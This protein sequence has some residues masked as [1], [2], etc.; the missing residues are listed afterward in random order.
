MLALLI[1]GTLAVL[2]VAMV[3]WKIWRRL[4]QTQGEF[5]TLQPNQFMAA[6][7]A[8]RTI[9]QMNAALLRFQLS[10]DPVERQN[11]AGFVRELKPLI[12]QGDV[13]VRDSFAQYLR[14]TAGLLEHPLGAVRKDSADRVQEQIDSASM[15]LRHACT[16]WARQQQT[17]FDQLIAAGAHSAASGRRLIEI[18]AILLVALLAG[19]VFVSY[20][21]L[22]SRLRESEVMLERQE[23]LA[24][25]GTLATGIAHEIRNPLA[26]IK[27]R[28]FSLK[29]TLPASLG[30][31]EDLVV[32]KTQIDRLDQ[33]LK[34]FLQFARPAE[35]K[36]RPVDA[37]RLLQ[38]VQA[39]L[40]AQLE[41]RS[42]HL[43]AE[44]A[45]NLQLNGDS[46]QLEQVLVNLVQNAADSVN[47]A[48]TI[49]LR[50]RQGVSKIR[51]ESTPL[52]IL[53]VSDT[54]RGIPAD[55]Q[56]RIFDPF[57]STKESGT[58]LGLAI[59]A[60]IIEKHGGFIQYQSQPDR[61]TTF[62]IV[63]PRPNSD[64]SENPDH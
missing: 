54:G 9:E 62:S 57:F 19:A 10:N 60:R 30:G 8:Q 43:E 41:R 20:A 18:S 51:R 55:V 29:K 53:E 5:A 1:G 34:D 26:A 39:L 21:P 56:E 61:G 7:L 47:D 31:H 12:A 4:A 52:V 64:V 13:M 3:E 11:F 24:S 45:D 2:G 22:R 16:E 48:G 23:K 25:L 17:S 42:I 63:L 46:E 6:V 36:L 49:T 35:P 15:A 38:N 58:G 27:L 33:M 59:A 50:A 28:L 44:A 37:R 40:G 32:I 14:T